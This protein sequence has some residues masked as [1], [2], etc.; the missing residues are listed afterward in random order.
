MGERNAAGQ[1]P[2]KNPAN[3]KK[4]DVLGRDAD[5]AYRVKNR[6]DGKRV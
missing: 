3:K 6:I 1:K 4:I 5:G 2:S